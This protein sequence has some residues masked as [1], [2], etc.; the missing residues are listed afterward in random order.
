MR[1]YL[2]ITAG[3]LGVMAIASIGSP[4]GAF[5]APKSCTN[6]MGIPGWCGPH[7]DYLNG[8][9]QR[10]TAVTQETRAPAKSTD[11]GHPG[12][13]GGHDGGGDGDGDGGDGDNGDG[14][15]GDNGRSDKH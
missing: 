15:D 9:G 14:G 4:A 7:N 5:E 10:S 8:E 6:F 1:K 11:N 2:L 13:D 3:V 12:C